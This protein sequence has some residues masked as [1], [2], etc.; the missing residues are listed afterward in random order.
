MLAL[1]A[2]IFLA[3]PP[4]GHSSF[5]VAVAAQ[6]APAA[7]AGAP[8]DLALVALYCAEP[9]AADTLTSFFTNGTPPKGCASAVGVRFDVT[10]NGS[11]LAGS[12]FQT[13]TTGAV[14]VQVGLGSAVT[15]REDPKS[16]PSGYEPLTQNANG[17]P[18]ANP[19]QLDSAAA[20]TAALFINVPSSVAAK[21]AQPA[22]TVPACAPASTPSANAKGGGV[23][24]NAKAPGGK[25]VVNGSA[26]MPFASGGSALLA[27]PA[28][29]GDTVVAGASGSGGGRAAPLAQ[30]RAG[31]RSVQNDRNRGGLWF[32][33]NRASDGDV[34]IASSPVFFGGG[35]WTARDGTGFW[36]APNRIGD[37][38]RFVPN[39]I[40]NGNINVASGGNVAVASNP[41]FIGGGLWNWPGR[42]FDGAGFGFGRN[43]IANGNINV[44]SSGNVA[45]ASNP[46]F[47]GR[48]VWTWPNRNGDNDGHPVWFWPNTKISNGNINVASGGNVAI[49]SNPVF[50]GGG[51]W[52]WP[53]RNR[54]GD[55]NNFWFWPNNLGTISNGAINVA[56]SGNVAIASNPVLIAGGLWT[57]PNRNGGFWF[58]QNLIANGNI[59]VSSSGNVAI[60]SNP[61]LIGGGLWTWSGHN[62]NGFGFAPNLIA[63]GNINVASGGNVAIASNPVLISS[64]LWNWSGSNHNDNWFA[65]GDRA[66]G[67]D[68]RVA[69]DNAPADAAAGAPATGA[70]TSASEQPAPTINGGSSAAP[71]ANGGQS[72]GDGG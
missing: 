9:P 12:P 16:L 23:A 6:S 36:F 34:A 19:V 39:F 46:V 29:T 69:S 38:S 66:N 72:A 47:V 51:L 20:G 40:A 49:A 17:V 15:V 44:A 7:Q 32:T 52:T 1:V 70:Q 54:N 62:G 43:Q 59:N 33:S 18:Y 50:I 63:N 21:L 68:S 3:A 25:T 26:I 67:D 57:L 53:N 22:A 45:V 13:D 60:A 55:G 48:G 64:G 28:A 10:E 27:A 8:T 5:V 71:I 41:V 14:G 37:G 42:F 58:G 61:V 4:L 35:L 30:T 2:A 31:D 24:G 65:Q 11:A 56:S